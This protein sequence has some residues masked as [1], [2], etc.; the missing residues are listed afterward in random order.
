MN[1]K[2]ITIAL[3]LAMTFSIF[4]PLSSVSA[5]GIPNANTIY[6][7]TIGTPE[8]VD[9][10]WAYDTASGEII[11]NI[12]EPLCMFDK[13]D[14]SSYV[15]AVADT[16]P[17]Y[18][19]PGNVLVP[20][21]P[22][23]TAPIG[24]NQTWYFHIRTG[25]QWQNPI[26]GTV[27][28]A[29]VEYSF[30][31]GMLFDHT[32][33]PMWMLYEPLLG[34]A[35]S[36]DYDITNAT[37]GDPDGDIQPS[38]FVTLYAAVTGAIGSNSTHA[39]FNLVASYAPFQQI[40]SQTW[41][42]IMSKQWSIATGLWNPT[43]VDLYTE[44]KR[45]WDPPSPGPLMNPA[46]AMGSGPYKLDAMDED[47][48]T[49]FFRL[50][51]FANFHGLWPAPGAASYAEYVVTKSVNEWA[52]RKAQFLST[53]PNLQ[54]D[55]AVIPR[56]NVPEIHD[57]GDKDA[58]VLPGF[59]YWQ[60]VAPSQALDAI[61]YT[62]TIAADSA[63]IPKMGLNFKADLM[64]DRHFRLAMSYVFNFTTYINDVMLGE[65]IQSPFCAPPG[66]LYYNGSKPMYGIDLVKAQQ[67]LDLA[68]GGA[69]KTQGLT[70]QFTYNIGNTA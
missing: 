2:Y 60:P 52:N 23:P 69:L 40:L 41:S 16:W 25:V 15:G 59:T 65:A 68:W 63:Y 11:Q 29:D 3:M 46:K 7:A 55:F 31:R 70:M 58:A 56:S 12:Y 10:H 49:G 8:T 45:Q 13:L 34:G 57:G 51:R 33:G 17:G 18:G 28:P 50:A 42:V 37:G 66:T 48:N 47:P 24:T 32:N 38:E 44:F 53:D 67:H 26:Y 21:P 39:W 35:S 19:T 62:Y 6:Y 22:D 5:V 20:S 61:Y 1:R 30:E 64:T 36:Y 43:V 14:P 4:L 27:T 9:P 54:A